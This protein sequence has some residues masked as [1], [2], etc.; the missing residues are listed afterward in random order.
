M[1]IVS[2]IARLWLATTQCSSSSNMQI[3]YREVCL[4]PYARLLLHMM[5]LSEDY[6]VIFRSVANSMVQ[7]LIWYPSVYFTAFIKFSIVYMQCYIICAIERAK[8]LELRITWNG[9]D[10]QGWEEWQG[11]AAEYPV[12]ESFLNDER[13]TGQRYHPLLLSRCKFD[14]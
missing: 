11:S 9:L 2:K 12:E 1:E 14:F 4:S 8:S 7:T 6:P 13:L 3:C 5:R 10:Q